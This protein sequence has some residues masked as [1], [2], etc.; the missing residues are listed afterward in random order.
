MIF[1][2]IGNFGS[3]NISLWQSSSKPAVTIMIFF[4]QRPHWVPLTPHLLVHSRSFPGAA[5]G[6]E[7][8]P[9]A[10]RRFGLRLRFLRPDAERRPDYNRQ[11]IAGEVRGQGAQSLQA[12]LWKQIAEQVSESHADSVPQEG[13]ERQLKGSGGGWRI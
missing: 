1:S 4:K 13:G 7:G 12:R 9:A 8:G 5:E 10:P 6:A 11:E 2:V 3:L